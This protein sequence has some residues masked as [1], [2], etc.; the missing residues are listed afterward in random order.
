MKFLAL[1][2]SVAL[3]AISAASAQETDEAA[4]AAEQPQLVKAKGSFQE[5][6]VNPN[7][8]FTRFD[9]IYLWEGTF[10]Y[11]DVGPARSTRTTMMNTR[12]REFGISDADRAKFEE[13]VSKAFDAEIAKGKKF[14]ITD[15]LGPGTMILRG[16]AL[17]IISMVPP[18]T[19]G[20]SEV[21]VSNIGEATLV[22][23]LLDASNGEVLA[24]VA[25][26]QRLQS[27]SGRIDSFSM[28]TSR[29]TVYAEVRRWARRAAS[30]LR[31]EL[32][33]AIAGK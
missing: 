14:T 31:V 13:E 19:V 20:R 1:T 6:W 27:G 11:R 16:G 32:D 7:A 10:E 9:K 21:Y 30:K 18:E 33:K 2:L 26:R 22:L 5:T 15:Q 4:N 8:D 23:E 24:V 12:Q 3:L 17:D 25:E 28:P 29:A